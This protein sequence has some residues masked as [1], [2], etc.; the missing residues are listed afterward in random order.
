MGMLKDQLWVLD[1]QLLRVSVYDKTL[2]PLSMQRLETMGLISLLDGGAMVSQPIPDPPPRIDTV[3]V[4]LLLMHPDGSQDRIASWVTNPSPVRVQF[5]GFTATARQPLV[6]M[7]LWDASA[8]GR[9]IVFVHHGGTGYPSLVALSPTGE[10]LFRRTIRWPRVPVTTAAYE[11]T[12]DS[13]VKYLEGTRPPTVTAV[14]VD[15]SAVRRAVVRPRDLSAVTQVL[16]GTDGRIWVRRRPS[17][18]AP[19]VEWHS[20]SADGTPESSV[21]VPVT[22]EVHVFTNRA[23]WGVVQEEGGESKVVEYLLPASLQRQ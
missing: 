2:T 11:Q 16:P 10:T 7:P 23:L 21:L 18:N 4:P 17:L 15:R 6:D 12:V 19:W 1:A 14:P 3:T 8:D 20:F 9:L 13:M 22:T 5:A